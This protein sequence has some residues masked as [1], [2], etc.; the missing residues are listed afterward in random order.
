MQKD[1]MKNETMTRCQRNSR[2]SDKSLK[3]QELRTAS[4]PSC[5]KT[6]YNSSYINDSSV[7]SKRENIKQKII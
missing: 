6:V 7:Q 4:V 5:T 2:S 1:H 3:G